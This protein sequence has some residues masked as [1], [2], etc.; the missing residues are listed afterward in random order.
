MEHTQ[1]LMLFAQEEFI[2]RAVTSQYS[3]NLVLKGGLLLYMTNGFIGRPTMDADYLL[4][5]YPNDE[6][7]IRRLLEHILS[8]DSENDF[9]RFEIVK[10]KRIAEGQHY[11]GMQA[12]LCA[13]IKR[14]RIPFSIDFGVGDVVIPGP[15]LV[16]YNSILKEEA[17]LSVLSYSMESIIAE[18]YDAI[19]HRLGQTSRMK[20]F[21]DIYTMSRQREFDGSILLRAIRETLIYRKRLHTSSTFAKIC[22]L[23]SDQDI[24][25][26]WVNFLRDMDF[27]K[28]PFE[29]VMAAIA[30]FLGPVIKALTE[31]SQYSSTWSRELGWHE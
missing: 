17:L 7:S 11:H 2:R 14:V 10:L 12:K 1:L 18:K 31:G 25:K 6:D 24:Q 27:E 3:D 16:I 4:Q 30:Q 9:V 19:A 29:N 13:Y 5:N 28:L 26:R 23:A 21:Y 15:S 22:S 8:Q 20:D